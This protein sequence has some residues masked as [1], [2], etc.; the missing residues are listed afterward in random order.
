MAWLDTIRFNTEIPGCG[1]VGAKLSFLEGVAALCALL[2]DPP[3]VIAKVVTIH[4]D[5]LGLFLAWRKGSSRCHLTYSILLALKALERA[6]YMRLELVKIPQC[7]SPQSLVADMLSKGLIREVWHFFP[8]RRPEPGSHSSTLLKWL[9]NPFPTRIL[10]AAIAKEL[11]F[12]INIANCD[13]EWED[14]VLPLVHVN[15]DI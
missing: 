3:S 14:E 6:L 12:K 10:G 11:S 8:H 5:N 13:F 15:H 2:A 1:R 7:S 9:C 4:T